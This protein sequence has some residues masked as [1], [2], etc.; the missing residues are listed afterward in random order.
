MAAADLS[1]ARLR[2]LLHYDPETGVFR[3]NQT[4]CGRAMAG[5]VAGR[6]NAGGYWKINVERRNHA[7]HRLA[8]LYMIGEWPSGEVDHIN[9]AK[10]DNRWLNLRDVARV[11]NM[12][13]QRE[14]HSNSKTGMLGV[15]FHP[16]NGKFQARI[17]VDKKP[18]SLGYFAKAEDASAAYR[19]AKRRL[20]AGC[21]L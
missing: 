11:V 7:A 9:G 4:R 18:K 3:W 16:K 1:A 10:C 17:Q 15:T 20:H 2:E 13:N 14:A 6:L 8:F 5:A 21:T 12:Q 19:D